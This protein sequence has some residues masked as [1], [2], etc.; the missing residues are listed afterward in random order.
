MITHG[1][2]FC[3]CCYG[4]QKNR[5]VL[6]TFSFYTNIIKNL[7]ECAVKDMNCFS[8]P[9]CKRG[10]YHSL[11]LT[12]LICTILWPHEQGK[13]IATTHISA[14]FSNGPRPDALHFNTAILLYPTQ[15]LP[16]L[17]FSDCP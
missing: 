13:R 15:P 11:S 9:L 12:L 2:P 3:C 8:G 14:S 10:I 4:L 5:H 7:F 16:V 6:N 17:Q 1:F